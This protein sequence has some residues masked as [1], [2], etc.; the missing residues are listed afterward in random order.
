MRDTIQH[1]HAQKRRVLA[2]ALSDASFKSMEEAVLE[3]IGRFCSRL[4]AFDG[5]GEDE[6]SRAVDMASLAG[7]LS[8]DVMGTVCFGRSF[9]MLDN[10]TNR[11]ILDVLLYDL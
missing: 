8:F 1:R 5:D 9:E 7:Y 4:L 11:Y 10:P 2:Q 6:W 3:N